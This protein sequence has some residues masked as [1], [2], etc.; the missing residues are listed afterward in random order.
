M[1]MGMQCTYMHIGCLNCPKY[2][3]GCFDFSLPTGYKQCDACLTVLLS[4]LGTL[5]M[6]GVALLGWSS[7]EVDTI[8]GN[9]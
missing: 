2:A 8:Q 3:I 9:G 7:F 4:V 1:L 6:I 5:V